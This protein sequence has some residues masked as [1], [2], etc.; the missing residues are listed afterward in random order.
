M[1]FSAALLVASTAILSAF[2]TP[3]PEDPAAAMEDGLIILSTEKMPGATL[4]WY[5]DA[6]GNV[7]VA[8]IPSTAIGQSGCGDNQPLLCDSNNTGPRDAC[9]GLLNYLNDNYNAGKTTSPRSL[10]WKLDS[11]GRC[12]A[13]WANDASN[14][15]FGY[16]TYALS[17]AINVCGNAFVDVSARTG[18]V[19]LGDTCTT[20][21]TSNRPDGCSNI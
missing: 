21:C 18:N 7:T 8:S 11:G 13:S 4:T 10:C 6:P 16:L 2:A 1:H 14:L 12:C 3:V 17:D 5:G 20:Q 15:L 9:N 19:R